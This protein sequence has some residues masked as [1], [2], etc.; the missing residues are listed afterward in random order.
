MGKLEPNDATQGIE[1]KL[2][3]PE[4]MDAS[5]AALSAATG[6]SPSSN[7]SQNEEAVELGVSGAADDQA[8]SEQAPVEPVEADEG[9]D[10]EE[11]IVD[12]VNKPHRVDEAEAQPISPAA[13][14]GDQSVADDDAEAEIEAT[15]ALPPLDA[16]A[17]RDDEGHDPGDADATLPIATPVSDDE[18]PAEA[19]KT[20]GKKSK[21][22]KQEAKPEPLPEGPKD[23][24]ELRG[25]H[26]KP[27]TPAAVGA[28][29][30]TVFPEIPKKKSR[31]AL[32]AFGVVLG[33][34]LALVAIAYCVG[35]AVFAG[36]MYPNTVLGEHDISMKTNQEVT[37]L[38]QSIADDYTITV[39]G[40][41]FAFQATGA[42]L[43][44][45]IDGERIVNAIHQDMEPWKWPLYIAM[46][47]H[48]ET[49]LM[50][51][52]FKRASYETQLKDLISQFNA[53]AQAPVNATIV[54]DEPSQQFV[55]KKEEL[56]TQIDADATMEAVAE[57]VI[58]LDPVLVLSEEQLV[59]P[60]VRS[61]DPKLVEAAKQATAIVS[62][63][64]TFLLNGDPLREINGVEL[65]QFVSINEN[66]E[67][68]LNE[69]ELGAWSDAV[70]ES[71][72]TVG[73]E[74]TYTRADGKVITVKG[75]SYGW[76]VDKEA[77]KAAL[78]EAVKAGA[79]TQ[80]EVPFV[81]Q[82]AVYTSP[83]QR[84]WGNRYVDVDIAEQ[85]VRFYDENGKLFWETDCISGVPDGKH[86]TVR[87]VWKVNAKESPSLL[88]GFENG[89]KIYETKVTF[90]MPFEGNSIG[91]HDATWQPSFGGS[92]YANGYGSHGCVN[93]SYKAAEELYG[94]IQ[95]GDVVV[96]HS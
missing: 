92:M 64:V 30:A 19:V 16:S 48:D 50:A 93:L 60:T 34:L 7:G 43:G 53:T 70:V 29:D 95:E 39:R 9:A 59:Q 10:G 31:R 58:A 67:V 28:A 87:G 13:D 52:D 72:D 41:D 46:P 26:A 56:G 42:D 8:A 12:E 75:G 3:E 63:R 44:L 61:D 21:K 78:L 57:A 17:V 27:A 96:V 82:A 15:E 73:S 89:K 32:K 24:Q 77:L 37:G 81:T 88:K 1:E 33:V 85:H 11:A 66:M 71:L 90:W 74:R 38:L 6:E 18:A 35:V 79:T 20:K 91:F 51:V 83:G 25:K 84:D 62:A 65:S 23:P 76:E 22:K 55:V 69:A 49:D 4:A 54:F 47:H 2:N 45:S 36:R 14:D 94:L 40:G 5:E 80:I 86:D 68:A